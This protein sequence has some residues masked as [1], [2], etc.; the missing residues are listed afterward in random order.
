M[1]LSVICIATTYDQTDTVVDAILS[2]WQKVQLDACTEEAQ[3]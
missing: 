3:V 2:A 1:R